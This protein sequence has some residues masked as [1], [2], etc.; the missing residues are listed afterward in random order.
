MYLTVRGLVLRVTNYN[1]YDALL[2]VLTYGHG[3]LTV[4]ARG[5]RRKNS[6]LVAPCQLLA[7]SEFTL[8]E[9][10]GLYTINE[11]SVVELFLPIR[12]DLQRLSLCTY[13]A[14]VSDV[15]CQEDIPSPELLSLV[16]NCFHA[17]S[18]LGKSELMTKAVFEMRAACI[19]GYTPNLGGCAL[20][21][22]DAPKHFNVS[23]GNLECECCISRREAGL[24]FPVSLGTLDAM[25]FIC[26]CGPKQ[27][28]SFYISDPTVQEL[29]KITE[30]YLSTQL[31]RGFSSLDFY[32]TLMFET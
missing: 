24:R 31:E 13:F 1:D 32:K 18:K 5:L 7:Y 20:C 25:R 15:L 29:S 3:K 2:S 9:N 8:F 10:H 27:L 26:N 12:S 17:I 19:A 21:G 30:L 6:S 16:L 22:S 28:F 23:A 14:Q 4:K 11:A